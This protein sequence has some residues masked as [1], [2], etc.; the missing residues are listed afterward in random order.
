MRA[1]AEGLDGG[2]HDTITGVLRQLQ[3]ALLAQEHRAPLPEGWHYR[4]RLVV[5]QVGS[6]WR[7]TIESSPERS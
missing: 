7:F 5:N 1:T 4:R 3:T 2:H 6:N